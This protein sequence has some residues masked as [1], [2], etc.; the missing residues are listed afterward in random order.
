[1]F[2]NTKR[3][4]FSECTE[5]CGIKAKQV[6]NHNIMK[7]ALRIAIFGN[8]YSSIRQINRALDS[9]TKTTTRTRFSQ[10]QVMRAHEPVTFWREN[11]NW[12][13]DRETNPDSGKRFW[14]QFMRASKPRPLEWKTT[15]AMDLLHSPRGIIFIIFFLR[16][17]TKRL[18]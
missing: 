17:Q 7:Q 11:V 16:W 9:K 15:Y 8:S 5:S 13:V 12:G 10:Y 2:W 14:Q 1:M 6:R 3:D 4:N 18:D